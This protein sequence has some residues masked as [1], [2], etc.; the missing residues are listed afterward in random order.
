M[1]A[2]TTV[3]RW[4]VLGLALKIAHSK[5]EEIKINNREN[6]SECRKD[7]LSL[8]VKSG[9]ASWKNLCLA[10]DSGVVGEPNL[11]RAI[12]MKHKGPQ[13]ALN[14]PVMHQNIP[15]P[16]QTAVAEQEELS[17]TTASNGPVSMM[18]GVGYAGTTFT[19]IPHNIQTDLA[20]PNISKQNENPQS[21]GTPIEHDVNTFVL[22]KQD[23]NV[24]HDMEH[25]P[26][27]SISPH[28]ATQQNPE[29]V[30]VPPSSNPPNVIYSTSNYA[31]TAIT[32]TAEPR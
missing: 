5:L 3:N 8:W 27:N 14:D 24:V 28:Q 26:S 20:E 31:N 15:L 1:S 10:L 6:V 30:M 2:I 16:I 13:Q 19:N 18:C 21:I 4:E 25:F 32:E 9:K 23:I 22:I 11:A 29:E 7:M 12:A 17:F